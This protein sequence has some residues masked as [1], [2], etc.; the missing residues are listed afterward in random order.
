DR[1]EQALAA[2]AEAQRRSDAAFE[3]FRAEA[4]RRFTELREEIAATRAEADRRLAALQEEVAAAR[5]EADRRFAELAE[6]QRRSE[7]RGDRLEQ[8]L[9]ALAEAQRRTD[10]RV[11]DLDGLVRG[12]IH[13]DRYR[14]RPHRYRRLVAAPAVLSPEE[15]EALLREAEETGRLAPEEAEAL[16]EADVIV[17]GQRREGEGEVYVVVEVSAVIATEDVARA[18][19]RAGLLRKA[20]PQAEV[21]AAVAGPEIHPLARAAARDQG[22]WWLRGSHPFA[23]HEIPT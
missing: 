14:T 20:R 17:R 9:A 5:A 19:A 3:A 16:G 22:V 10:Q 15:R 7:E 12:M 4:D 2:L 6:A 1:L 13:E 23:P 21:M 11:S 18:A 8:A